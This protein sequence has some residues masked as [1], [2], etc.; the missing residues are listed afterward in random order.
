[1]CS[2]SR[3]FRCEHLRHLRGERFRLGRTQLV[4]G[5]RDYEPIKAGIAFAVLEFLDDETIAALVDHDQSLAMCS[6]GEQ[7]AVCKTM[8]ATSGSNCTR[9]LPLTSFALPQA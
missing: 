1:M 5:A 9:A 8:S 7:H 4:W 2:R 6:R 3:Q